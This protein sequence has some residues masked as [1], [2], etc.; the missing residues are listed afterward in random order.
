MSR[1]FDN[2][3]LIIYDFDNT[4]LIKKQTWSPLSFASGVIKF[5]GLLAVI[6]VAFIFMAAFNKW[7]FQTKLKAFIA[8]QQDE[9]R[10]SLNNLE[11]RNSQ[12]NDGEE[13]SSK[14]EERYSIE[15][16]EKILQTVEN[17]KRRLADVERKLE[18]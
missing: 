8:E 5:G 16:F 12:N 11:M 7:R 6:K 4:G 17:L 2:S 15:N 18:D 3:I 13:F 1:E 10:A 9:E 14:I